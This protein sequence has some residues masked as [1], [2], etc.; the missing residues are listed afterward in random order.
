M[1]PAT[2]PCQPASLPCPDPTPAPSDRAPGASDEV[3]TLRAMMAEQG[4]QLAA[5]QATLGQLMSALQ[6]GGVVVGAVARLDP[7]E[8]GFNLSQRDLAERLGLSPSTI[9]ALVRA[10][11]LDDDPHLAVTVRSGPRRLVNYHPD[12]VARF[13]ELLASPPST[14]DP[15]AQHTVEQARLRLGLDTPAP[16]AA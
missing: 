9:S 11:H 12:T 15:R 4:R 2:F 10:F 13:R 3:A 5:I 7:M 6:H 16:Q 1:A 8:A 14:L